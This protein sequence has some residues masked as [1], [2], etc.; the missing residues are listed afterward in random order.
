[1]RT[2]SDTASAL[3]PVHRHQWLWEPL[4]SDPTFLLRSMFGTRAAYLDGRLV[5]CFC[6]RQEPWR[7]VLVCTEREHQASLRAEFPSLLPHPILPKWLYLPESSDA[8][9]SIATRLV[10]AARARDPRLGIISPKG[11]TTRR[12]RGPRRARDHP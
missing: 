4:Q 3:R 11:K 7:G 2:R 9:E 5:L 6:A 12:R 1:M 10:R 8:F